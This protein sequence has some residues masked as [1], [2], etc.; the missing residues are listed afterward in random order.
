MNIM[1]EEKIVLTDEDFRE[2]LKEFGTYVDITE[3]DLKRLY[4]IAVKIARE[5]CIHSWLAREIMTQD[6]V[7]VKA[8]TDIH[9]AG[10]LLI[11]NKISGMPVVDNENRVVGMICTSDLLMF[12][13]IPSGHVFNDVIMKYILR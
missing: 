13:G 5:R 7:S 9:E 1:E 6:V 8:D 3:E 2:A 4:E 10:K 12:A 11:K